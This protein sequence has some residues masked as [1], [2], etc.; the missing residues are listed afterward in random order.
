M[1][2]AIIFSFQEGLVFAMAKVPLPSSFLKLGNKEIED[3]A[4]VMMKMVIKAFAGLL[5]I[6]WVICWV[7][8]AFAGLLLHLLG[9]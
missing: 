4:V 9:Y 6:C 7:I 3:E 8:K 5:M 1:F 2:L